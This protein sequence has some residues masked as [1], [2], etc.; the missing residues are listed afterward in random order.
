[1][2][3]FHASRFAVINACI[4][5]GHRSVSAKF[6]FLAVVRFKSSRFAPLDGPRGAESGDHLQLETLH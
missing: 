4:I 2:I 1:V 3:I 6:K 5:N